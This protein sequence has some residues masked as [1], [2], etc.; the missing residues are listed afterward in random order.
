LKLYVLSP[1]SDALLFLIFS[2]FFLLTFFTCVVCLIGNQMKSIGQKHFRFKFKTQTTEPFHVQIER[3]VERLIRSGALAAGQP[4]PS[5]RELVKIW[6]VNY[7]SIE[8]ALKR[9]KQRGL[10][11]RA[12]RRGTFVNV[13]AGKPMIA[14][15]VGPSLL[16]NEAGF[17]RGLAEKMEEESRRQGW[18][19][20]I[21]HGLNGPRRQIVSP[22][23]ERIVEEIRI[24]R[25]NGVIRVGLQDGPIIQMVKRRRMPFV[26]LGGPFRETTVD[27][28]R[29]AFMR[30]VFDLFV[31]HGCRRPFYLRTARDAIGC[32]RDLRAFRTIARENGLAVDGKNVWQ[33]PD[34]ETVPRLS[35]EMLGYEQARGMIALWDKAQV[36]PDGLIVFDDILMKGVALALRERGIRVPEKLLVVCQATA[37]IVYPYAVPVMRIEY[38]LAE[39]A[40]GLVTVLDKRIRDEEPPRLPVLLSPRVVFSERNKI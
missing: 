2:D 18:D 4:L 40:R 38:S 37:D 12:P 19:C 14:I 25:V 23:T 10:L 32:K 24:G 35:I 6:Q 26:Q 31:R 27:F 33:V 13:R 3:H 30:I 9:L 1:C 16:R 29:L 20:R 7:R 21:H 39:I 5:S 15:L 28:D 11:E 34:Y 8:S 17:Y 22:V 36:R